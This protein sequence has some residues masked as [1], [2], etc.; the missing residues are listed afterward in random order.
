MTKELRIAL[1]AVVSMTILLLGYKFIIGKSLLS[2]KQIFYVKYK[3]ID[4]LQVSN[5]VLING[6]EVGGVNKIF[7]DPLDNVT[8]V[9]ELEVKNDIKIPKNAKAILA[10]LGLMGGKGIQLQFTG[11]CTDCAQSGDYLEGGSK[12]LLDNF[13]GEG[14]I[15]EY[16]AKIKIG[17]LSLWDTLAGPDGKKEIREGVR[18][19]EKTLTNLAQSTT[20]LNNLLIRNSKKLDNVISNFESISAT[21]QSSN[22]EISHIIKNFD[23]LSTQV[24]DVN[25][26]KTVGEFNTTLQESKKAI[27][28]LKS[29]L[30]TAEKSLA[31]VNSLI[32]KAESGDGSAAKILNDPALYNN[33]SETSRQITL[34]LQDLRL[35]PKRYVNVSVFGK[36]Q[37]EYV[38]IFDDPAA[39]QPDSL[40]K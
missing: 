40:K 26:T 39:M 32:K 19:F 27:L 2:K 28:E 23:T 13:I 30:T 4:Q 8:P 15:D 20:A 16:T 29:T 37:K 14:Q 34:F 33:L 3:D 35:N 38:P 5:P 1:L 36:K 24:K 12:S 17:A 6:F 10:S 9:V 18:N 11:N 21:F 22:K 7:L 31:S 25:I